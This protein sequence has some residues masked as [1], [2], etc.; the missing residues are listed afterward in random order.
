MRSPRRRGR[1]CYFVGHSF[2]S[3]A[4]FFSSSLRTYSM[5]SIACLAVFIAVARFR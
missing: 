3:S 4:C 2:Q 5:F 1:D